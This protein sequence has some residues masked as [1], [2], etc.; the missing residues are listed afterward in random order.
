MHSTDDLDD[1]EDEARSK[2]CERLSRLVKAQ[3]SELLRY[4]EDL[5][6]AQTRDEESQ[7]MI[8]QLRSE[9]RMNQRTKN[10]LEYEV[11][12]LACQQEDMTR[13]V[14]RLRRQ[15]RT[16]P[17]A[18]S[19]HCLTATETMIDV[20][21]RPNAHGPNAQM[22]RE[23]DSAASRSVV[24]DED[25]GEQ[26]AAADHDNKELSK[27][28]CVKERDRT[29]NQRPPPSSIGNPD[30]EACKQVQALLTTTHAEITV[31]L[32]RRIEKAK[33]RALWIASSES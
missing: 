11:R 17:T 32:L 28:M 13:E 2:R 9:T 29:H 24:K 19:S 6:L 4:E 20:Y 23:D 21:H 22:D 15:L 27:E 14:R 12:E 3:E 33:T 8:A 31:M 5:A 25:M 18:P 7:A 1:D 30:I 10:D 16:T 26:L